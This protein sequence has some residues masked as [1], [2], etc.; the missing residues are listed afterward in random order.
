MPP[1][2]ATAE[3]NLILDALADALGPRLASK[4][5][6]GYATAYKHDTPGSPITIGYSHGPGGNFS[7]PGVDP[8]VFHTVVG[9]KGILGQL[10]VNGSLDTN[11]T[12]Q[13]LTGVTS[14]VGTEKAEV[15]DDAPVAGLAKGCVLTSVFGRYERQTQEIEI[16]RLGQRVDRSDPMDLALVGSPISQTGLFTTG[17]GDPAVPS[18]MFSNEVARKFWELGVSLHRLISG[19]LWSGNPANNNGDAYRELTGFELLVNTGHVDALTGSACLSIDSDVRD[20]GY[21][22]VDDNG[23]LMVD[24]MSSVYHFVKDL[25]ERT[26]MMPV[27]W[28]WAMRPEL[29]WELTAVWPCSYLTYRCDLSAN[30]QATVNIDGAEQ[31]RMRDELRTG[32][33]LIIDGDRIDVVLD[34]GISEDTNTTNG[35]VPSG[36]MSS[37]IF[38]IPMSVVGG[39]AVTF[40]QFFQYENPSIRDAMN[41]MILGRIEGPWITWPKQTNLCVQ[42]QTKIEPRLI[43]R[44]PWLAGRIQH[45]V[46]CPAKHT[47][48]PFP[49][50]PYFVNTGATSRP[51]PSYYNLWNTPE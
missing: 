20:F 29:F 31:V 40:L 13:V 22:R 25:A 1:A 4:G 51:G 32:R 10:P 47:R 37:D 36:C 46:Y 2:T 48:E 42:W 18:D 7:V 14:D 45:V 24:M 23:T 8:A 33:Y 5:G 34:D 27:R 49:T 21:G 19:Q 9:N 28:V 11:P 44:T 16:N 50:D 6:G 39:R 30:P 41:N 38:L 15:C 17:P 35:S 26:G 3:S 12:Y 43:M